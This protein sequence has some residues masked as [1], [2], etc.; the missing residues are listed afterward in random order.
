MPSAPVAKREMVVTALLWLFKLGLGAVFLVAGIA[1]LRDPALFAEE[2]ANYQLYPD[3]APYLA[4]ALPCIEV[5]VGAA[6]VV[7]PG[8]SLWLQA[9]AV[10][11][12]LMMIA[13]TVATSHVLAEGINIDCGCFGGDSGPVSSSTVLRDVTLILVSVALFVLARMRAA[14]VAAKQA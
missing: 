14:L 9:A 5:L 11:T 1:K 10:C 13:F 8:R 2:I 6:L 7:T 4:A 12:T 3:T